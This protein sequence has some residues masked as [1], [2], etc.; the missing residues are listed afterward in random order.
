[1]RQDL[2]DAL[3]LREES[4]QFG[5][6]TLIVREAASAADLGTEKGDPDIIYKLMIACIF[7]ADGT[8]PALSM[9]DLPALKAGSRAKVGKLVDATLRVNGLDAEDNAGKSEANPA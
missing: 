9:E 6:N 1:M 7:E 8:T 2:L 5:G 4:V 3:K